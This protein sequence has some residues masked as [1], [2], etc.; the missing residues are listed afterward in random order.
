[1]HRCDASHFITD[2]LR[3]VG[4][5]CIFMHGPL[6]RARTSFSKGTRHGSRLY[7]DGGQ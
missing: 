6:A 3:E 7:S 4:R 1:M 5:R 2:L